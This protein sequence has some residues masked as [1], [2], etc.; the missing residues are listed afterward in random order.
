MIFA[1]VKHKKNESLNLKIDCDMVSPQS[2]KEQPVA[3]FVKV[4]L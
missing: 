4:M 3:H 1:L 2:L